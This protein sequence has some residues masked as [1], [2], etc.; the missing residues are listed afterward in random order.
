MLKSEPVNKL[1]PV[2]ETETAGYSSCQQWQSRLDTNK[3]QNV[4]L[5]EKVD[6]DCS[7]RS[8]W[9]FTL[10]FFDFCVSAGSLR[11]VDD[12]SKKAKCSLFAFKIVIPA[13]ILHPG[14]FLYD[15]ADQ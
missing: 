11:E 13:K 3:I 6:L 5:A 9:E 7:Y 15:T 14:D 2:Y 1:E 8:S 4:I 12:W 10:L